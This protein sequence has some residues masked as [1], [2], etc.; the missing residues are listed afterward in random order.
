MHASTCAYIAHTHTQPMY[1]L[2]L[3]RT[4]KSRC[5]CV[6]AP[7]SRVHTCPPPQH[8]GRR[9]TKDRQTRQTDTQTDR[10]SSQRANKCVL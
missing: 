6:R 5:C 4:H 3:V 2:T 9:H 1:S 10:Q 8:S 7:T